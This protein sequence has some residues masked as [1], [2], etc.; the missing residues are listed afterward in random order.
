MSKAEVSRLL[1]TGV[2]WRKTLPKA[3]KVNITAERTTDGVRAAM[4]AYSQ[5]TATTSSILSR[6]RLR[7]RR[8]NR[9]ESTIQYT[10]PTCMPDTQST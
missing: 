4:Q 9:R 6:R 1:Y 10:I 3:T 5:M 7:R 2:C 8:K